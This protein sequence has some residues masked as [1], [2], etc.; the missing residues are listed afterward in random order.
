MEEYTVAAFDMRGYGKSEI[1]QVGVRSCAALR[2]A[3][4]PSGRRFVITDWH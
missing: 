1:P 3:A 2:C 4:L